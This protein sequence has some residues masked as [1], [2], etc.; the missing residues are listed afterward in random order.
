[1]GRGPRRVEDGGGEGGWRAALDNTMPRT[2]PTL[3]LSPAANI[4]DDDASAAL[5]SLPPPPSLAASL[6]GAASAAALLRRDAAA[7]RV[8]TFV[9]DLDRVLGGGVAPGQLTEFCEYG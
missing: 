8:V 3:P 1:M 5:A 6:P 9:A 7:T 4:T 2:N